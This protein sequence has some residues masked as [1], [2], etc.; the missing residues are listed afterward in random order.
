MEDNDIKN[1]IRCWDC[2][3][4]LHRSEGFGRGLSEAMYLGK[5]V[6]ATA[7]SGNMDFMTLENSLPVNYQLVNVPN[8]AYPFGEGQV[9][10]EPDLEDA[11]NHMLRL[12]D[13][14]SLGRGMGQRASLTIRRGFWVPK[15]WPS[16]FSPCPGNRARK[17]ES[18]G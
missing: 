8:G 1:L 7:Y 17:M 4:S 2:F 14:S 13:D 12:I 18:E 11:V 5:P 10:A 9:W 15:N 16:I 6:I 3:V